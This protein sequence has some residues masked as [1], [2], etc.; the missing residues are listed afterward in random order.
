MFEKCDWTKYLI[1]ILKRNYQSSNTCA[2]TFVLIF[3]LI[4]SNHNIYILIVARLFKIIMTK[5]ETSC[6]SDNDKHNK[7]DKYRLDEALETA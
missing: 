5:L 2:V 6:G 1:N 3:S 4:F 7:H